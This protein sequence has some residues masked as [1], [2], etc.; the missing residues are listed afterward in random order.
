MGPYPIFNSR[1]DH[2][3]SDPLA[4]IIKVVGLY[5]S[6]N[7]SEFGGREVIRGQVRGRKPKFLEMKNY[8]ILV[9]LG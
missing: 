7:I 8:K 1:N 6:F 5:E 2:F 4:P 3:L 9:I